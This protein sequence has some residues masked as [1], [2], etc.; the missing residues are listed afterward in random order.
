MTTDNTI[1][2]QIPKF[3]KNNFFFELE[4][5]KPGRTRNKTAIKAIAGTISSKPII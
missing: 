2:A 1:I 3:L 4:L 5:M